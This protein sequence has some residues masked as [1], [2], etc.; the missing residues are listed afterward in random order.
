VHV[1]VGVYAA[2]N[3]GCLYDGQGHPFLRLR[4]GTHPLAVGPGKPRPLAQDGQIRPARRWVPENLGP[5]DRSFRRTTR[6][7]SAES[8][9]R[10]D[11][12][13]RPYAP[14]KSKPGKQGRKHYPHSPCRIFASLRG[15]TPSP[16][17]VQ[18][19]PFGP[20][21]SVAARS[22]AVPTAAGPG[23]GSLAITNAP[24]VTGG[25]QRGHGHGHSA[26]PIDDPLAGVLGN[27]CVGVG[28]T[29]E[30]RRGLT[31]VH[32]APSS[33]SASVAGG[34]WFPLELERRHRHP[35]PRDPR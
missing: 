1:S 9:V 10:P 26:V 16:Y 12:G 28:S 25:A 27:G 34:W 11:P 3:G 18:I 6:T 2:S 35:R 32:R 30:A 24:A 8:E 22:G 20:A 13:P 23:A 19:S 7:A 33:S 15:R 29:D 21:L 31:G 14:A 4:G 17:G 5:A